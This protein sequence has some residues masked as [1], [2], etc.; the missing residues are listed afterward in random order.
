MRVADSGTWELATH[1]E[2]TR[3]WSQSI[4]TTSGGTPYLRPEQVLL[5]KA[6]GINDDQEPRVKDGGDFL[7]TL[8]FLEPSARDW[9]AGTLS[10]LRPAHPWLRA[11][12]LLSVK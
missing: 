3:P 1:P 8:P 6:M 11:L 5:Y 4:E 10:S 9:L 2:V 12:A 7:Y